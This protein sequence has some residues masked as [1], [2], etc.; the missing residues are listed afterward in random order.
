[1]SILAAWQLLFKAR[2][3]ETEGSTCNRE[4]RRLA[5]LS[6]VGLIIACTCGAYYSTRLDAA[7]QSNLIGP[8][9]GIWLGTT[10]LGV[11][12]QIYGWIFQF[13]NTCLCPRMLSMITGGALATLLGTASLRE[14]VRIT[15][16]DISQ[17]S[18]EMNAAY[19]IGGFSLFL[20]FALINTF[21]I[22]ICINIVR[23]RKATR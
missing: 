22:V 6:V 15:R 23:R 8:L 16:L 1:M 17:F 10:I 11:V 9:G 20:V 13:R 2:S 12:L 4:A 18:D 7:T 19:S 21:L 14:I 5:V 3:D